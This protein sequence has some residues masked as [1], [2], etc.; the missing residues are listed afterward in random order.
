M[1]P[2]LTTLLLAISGAVALVACSEDP[3]QRT[4]E[5]YCK[6]VNEHLTDLN[7]PVINTQADI[8]RVVA[9]WRQVAATAPL[10]VQEEWSAMVDNV[11]TASTVDPS[12]AAS[13]QRVADQARR[14]EPSANKVIQYTQATCG[15]TIGSAGTGP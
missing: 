10:A 11:E 3:A 15:V 2:R 1:L 12:D 5:N 6:T 4:E 14:T 7:A 8:D 9:A 13:V